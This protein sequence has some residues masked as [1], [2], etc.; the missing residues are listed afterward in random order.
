[1]QASSPTWKGVVNIR[2]QFQNKEGTDGEGNRRHLDRARLGR[3]A[4]TK[5]EKLSE[6]EPE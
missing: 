3:A 5:R 2:S 4:A 1:M 6:S